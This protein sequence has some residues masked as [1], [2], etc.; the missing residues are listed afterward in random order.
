MAIDVVVSILLCALLVGLMGALDARHVGRV[1]GQWRASYGRGC[2]VSLRCIQSTWH[3]RP[4]VSCSTE[5]TAVLERIREATAEGGAR[6]IRHLVELPGPRVLRGVDDDDEYNTSLAPPPTL[7]LVDQREWFT[8][9][10]CPG[11]KL[12]MFSRTRSNDG[13]APPV[14][15]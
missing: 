14:R 15:P 10:G 8:L 2:T 12:R 7:Y 9:D 5:F 3:G 11:L 6:G 4:S 1:L 13:G